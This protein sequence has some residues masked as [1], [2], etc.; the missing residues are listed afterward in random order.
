MAHLTRAPVEEQLTQSR[1]SR[2]ASLPSWTGWA[3]TAVALT[4]GIAPFA[5]YILGA[6]RE[7]S[8]IPHA[9]DWALLA[10]QPFKLQ[11]HIAAALAAL[12]VG[13]VIMMRPKGRGAHMALGWTWVTAMAL[14]AVSSLFI[15]TLR[16]GYSLLHLLS[17]WTIIALPMAVFAIRRGNVKAHRSAMTGM[18]VGGLILAGALNFLPGRLIWRVFFG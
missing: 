3:V 9:P 14:T 15:T 11:V 5:P 10:N 17:G 16:D 4:A 13:I 7:S 1:K 6:A 8:W 2:L 12:A 18:F